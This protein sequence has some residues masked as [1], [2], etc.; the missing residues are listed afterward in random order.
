MAVST[1]LLCKIKF[2]AG[3]P[4]KKLYDMIL[5]VISD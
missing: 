4:E 3:P 2:Y 5:V 1:Q